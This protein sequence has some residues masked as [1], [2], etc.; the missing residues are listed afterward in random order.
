M[1]PVETFAHALMLIAVGL[2]LISGFTAWW[3]VKGLPDE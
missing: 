3:F 1:T 2:T